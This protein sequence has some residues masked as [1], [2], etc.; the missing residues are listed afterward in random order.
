[1]TIHSDHP[2]RTPESGRGP[3]RRLRGRLAAPVTLW[4]ALDAAG[5]RAGLTVSS[6]LVADGEPAKMLALLDPDSDLWEAVLSTRTAVVQVLGWTD[7]GL[8]DAFAG[9][10]PAPG[11]PFRMAEWDDSDW[12]PVL[13]GTGAWAGVRLVD[14]EARGVGWAVAAEA[15]VEH[16]EIA[17]DVEP[18]VHRR[19]EYVRIVESG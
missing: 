18:L 9:L 13:R 3:V 16:V 15:V 14:D 1:V 12:G 11:G 17:D 5:D 8:A 7:R 2:F 6:T 10:A 19:G 4:T